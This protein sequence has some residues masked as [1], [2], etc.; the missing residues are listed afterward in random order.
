L[1]GNFVIV[2]ATSSPRLH[3]RIYKEA[4]RLGILCNVVDDPGTSG[5]L[6][7]ATLR[8]PGVTV[9]I[10]TGGHS[11]ALARVL[12]EYVASLLHP[13]WGRLIEAFGTLRPEVRR[14]LPDAGQRERFWRKT[15]LLALQEEHF[16]EENG[17]E[18][19]RQQLQEAIGKEV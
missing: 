12:K 4:R 3:A 5:F 15:A 11:P 2:A 16:L 1:S 8:R 9:A 17:E 18:W 10:G 13:G 6:V 19:L 14:C 7:P